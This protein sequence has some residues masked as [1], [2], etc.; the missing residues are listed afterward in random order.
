[1]QNQA[2]AESFI[3]FIREYAPIPRQAN[4]YHEEIEERAAHMGV[5]PLTFE[6]PALTR[7]RALF[8][9]ADAKLTN[10]VLTGTAGD[11]KTRLLYDFWRG[12]GGQDAL[13]RD[14]PK[15]APLKALVNGETRDFYFIF[16]L[17][18]CLPEK[19]QA[20]Q[21]GQLALLEAFVDSLSGQSPTIFLVAAND[22][23][24]LQALRSLKAT[25]PTSAMAE[26]EREVEEMLAAKRSTSSRLAI[27]L[28]DLSGI[29][30]AQTLDR[31]RDALLAR[32]EWKCFTECQADP[33]FG[34]DS[35]LRR[36]W[37]ILRQPQFYSR[38]RTLIELCDVNGFHISV[39][40]LIAMLVNGLLG[41]P[42]ASERVLTLEEARQLAS[43]AESI[44]GSIHRNVFGENLK[45]E[46]RQDFLVFGYLNYFRVG[47][48]TSNGIDEL[49]LFGH[50]L[51]HLKAKYER[52][53]IDPSGNDA[54]NPAFE[55]LRRD[56][57]E[58]EDFDEAKREEFL[59]ELA[60]Q[61]RRLFFRISDQEPPGFDP[62]HL[63]I[64]QYAGRFLKTILHPLKRG[65]SPDAA[66]IET[67]VRG[68]NRVW[69][70]M[71]FDE[72]NKLYLTSG[73]DFTS[74]RIS[75]LAL[76]A[77]PVC[78]SL[79]GERIEV[80]LNQRE[81]PELKV[82]LLGGAPICYRLDLMRFEFLARVAEG[83][84]PNSFSREC[85]EDVINFKSLLLARVQAVMAKREVRNF[86]YLT[87]DSKGRPAEET[88][89][90]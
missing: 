15:H 39:R 12:L 63:T 13:V 70:G 21:P 61:R 54:I 29:S 47:H 76:H 10:L 81:Q 36:N 48:E 82:H 65:D 35:S 5:L 52:I 77:V 79:T 55:A 14:Q 34:P 38:L 68:L 41:H 42:K 24:L 11:G 62:W 51:P 22:G 19:G 20:W 67:I 66:T 80:T 69:S 27:A 9:P 74:A 86:K 30:S 71:L 3:R 6:H 73:L 59:T 46:R 2:A 83:A 87:A 44:R 53:M 72:G 32:P 64:F 88:I 45:D 60:Q 75:R 28:L 31:A 17:S 7:I 23:K 49:I 18:K 26:V 84:L 56:Y 25:R 4:M 57:L 85:Y 50:E 78:E 43:P 1:M 8:S 37:E 16:D 33:A 58:A 90:L 40:D 89:N